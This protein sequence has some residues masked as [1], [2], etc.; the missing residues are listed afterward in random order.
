[1]DVHRVLGTHRSYLEV[2]EGK[3]SFYVT[4]IFSMNGDYQRGI[5]DTQSLVVTAGVRGVVET[6]FGRYSLRGSL[7]SEEEAV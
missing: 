2:L 4:I 7:L 6:T 3:Q 5:I 1:M